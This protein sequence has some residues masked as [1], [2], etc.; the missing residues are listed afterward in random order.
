M[1]LAM[2]TRPVRFAR[3]VTVIVGI[4]ALLSGCGSGGEDSSTSASAGPPAI[5]Q[6]RQRIAQRVPDLERAASSLDCEDALGVIHPIAL[7]DPSAG[8]SKANCAEAVSI[9]RRIQGFKASDSKDFGSAAL[10][11]AKVGGQ[12]QSLYWALDDG[13]DLKWIATAL[14][15]H[16][17]G[18]HPLQRID[19]EAPVDAFL[20]A[21]RD[22]DCK[23][24]YAQLAPGSRVSYGDP[25]TFC[26]KFG[27]TFTAD[28]ESFGTLLQNDPK[29]HPVKLGS[30]LDA[31][32]YGV[33]TKPNGYRTL[34]VNP[35][36]GAAKIYE[37]IPGSAGSGN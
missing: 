1:L 34:I 27:D 30:T 36:K 33:A 28:S 18:T 37:V 23:A 29:A 11:D 7:P 15:G 20:R 25:K 10:V 3:A 12:D 13:G 14:V 2:I 32:F 19:Y 6:P 26:S 8:R 5:P 16:Q 35:V 9:L 31:T 21:L 24:A 17:I 4:G 22:E